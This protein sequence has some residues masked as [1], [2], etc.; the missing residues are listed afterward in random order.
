MTQRMLIEDSIAVQSK[1]GTTSEHL[2]HA[3]DCG[4]YGSG[5]VAKL[6]ASP[7]TGSSMQG[8][9][10]QVDG[11]SRRQKEREAVNPSRSMQGLWGK[12]RASLVGSRC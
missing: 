8:Q 7:G 4:Q 1:I 11:S 2:R 5:G 9:R 6:I 12:I 10:D 3:D